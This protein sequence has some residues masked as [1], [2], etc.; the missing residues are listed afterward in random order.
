MQA[1]I[2]TN[3]FMYVCVC[4]HT[5]KHIHFISAHV[6]HWYVTIE[7]ATAKTCS[8]F[9]SSIKCDYLKKY[10]VFTIVSHLRTR[11]IW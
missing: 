11:L 7:K 5:H 9:Y 4:I 6:L 2:Q 1:N 8:I 10:L 3:V